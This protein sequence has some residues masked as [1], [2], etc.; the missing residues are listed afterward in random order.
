MYCTLHAYQI[1]Q[2]NI[3]PMY[4]LGKATLHVDT[5]YTCIDSVSCHAHVL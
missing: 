3:I 5:L 2:Y 1:G 4:N